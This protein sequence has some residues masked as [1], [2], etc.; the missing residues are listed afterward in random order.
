MPGAVGAERAA[1]SGARVDTV[2]GRWCATGTSDTATSRSG[3]SRSPPSTPARCGSR[4]RRTCDPRATLNRSWCRTQRRAPSAAAR[5]LATSSASWRSTTRPRSRRRGCGGAALASERRECARRRISRPGRAR[6]GARSTPAL[7][8]RLAPEATALPSRAGV[9]RAARAARRLC[10]GTRRAARAARRAARREH[11]KH[12]RHASATLRL[13]GGARHLA[14]ATKQVRI[15]REPNDRQEACARRRSR[16]PAAADRV[17]KRAGRRA[18][19]GRPATARLR[20]GGT[21][22]MPTGHKRH[23]R[24]APTGHKRRARNGRHAI[25]HAASRGH[26]APSRAPVPHTMTR[27]RAREVD[28]ARTTASTRAV[29]SAR[30]HGRHGTGANTRLRRRLASSRARVHNRS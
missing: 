14:G 12:A 13:S 7:E 1:A 20:H 28:N 4:N 3:A 29:A 24:N 18:R 10:P 15:G 23:A 17:R 19:A 11:P 16:G 27:A 21:T 5:R 2:A 30:R 25:T 8:R 9:P 22:T 26:P 6:G